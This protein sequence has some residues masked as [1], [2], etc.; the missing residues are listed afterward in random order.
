MKET[1]DFALR[2]K[3]AMKAAGYAIRPVVL[4]REFNQRYWGRPIS[5]QAV[6]RWL[7]GEAIPSQDKLQVLADWLDTEPQYLRFGDS[8]VNAINRRRRRWEE[9]VSGQEREVL[10][11]YISL[12]ASQK[13]IVR[14]MIVE[15]ARLDGGTQN[16]VGGK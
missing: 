8:S 11:A 15:L 6:R 16:E 5:L 10:E 12:P 3:A 4:E 9:A 2:L 1:E 14:A 13:K 7:R